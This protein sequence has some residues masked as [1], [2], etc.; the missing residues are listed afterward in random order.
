MIDILYIIES[1]ETEEQINTAEQLFENYCNAMYQI[2]YNIL[3]NR[4]DAEEAVGDTIVRICQHID[5][6]ITKPEKERRL[7]VKKYTERIS[8]DKYREKER[9]PSESLSDYIFDTTEGDND[10]SFYEDN[11]TFEAEDFGKLQNYVVKLPQK[12]KDI[13]ILKYINELK[14]KEI[15]ELLQIPESTVSTNLSRAKKYLKNMLTEERI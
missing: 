8:I 10:V 9:K 6:F 14:N 4:H 1:L 7:L 3:K 11:L 2:A 15:A 12:Y 13:L 5:D